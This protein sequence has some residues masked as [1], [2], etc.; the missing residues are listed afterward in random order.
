MKGIQNTIYKAHCWKCGQTDPRQFNFKGKNH[1]PD[2]LR[3]RCERCEDK[4]RLAAKTKKLRAV[5]GIASTH[6]GNTRSRQKVRKRVVKD[7]FPPYPPS[8]R[9]KELI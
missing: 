9:E 2:F 5:K 7:P 1:D 3:A 8:G 6:G 4:G